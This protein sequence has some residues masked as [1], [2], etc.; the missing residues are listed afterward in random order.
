MACHASASVPVVEN[1]AAFM[2]A[3]L[4][5]DNAD[6]SP[7]PNLP[8]AILSDSARRYAW[9]RAAS[10][11]TSVSRPARA[12]A[13]VR[14]RA[15]LRAGMGSGIRARKGAGSGPVAAPVLR[16]FYG[17]AP[18]PARLGLHSA[19]VTDHW[20]ASKEGAGRPLR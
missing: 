2:Y 18:P 1:V 17:Q 11:H 5:S 14:C 6:L 3:I 13:G 8:E 20:A 7:V 15:T 16:P 9:K 4:P 10:A 12:A 19:L